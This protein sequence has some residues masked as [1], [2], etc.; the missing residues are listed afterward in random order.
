[1]D[2]RKEVEN[3]GHQK[4]KEGETIE[5]E[6]KDIAAEEDQTNSANNENK[7]TTDPASN[8]TTP[9]LESQVRQQY[10]GMAI[11]LGLFPL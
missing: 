11:T 10:F 8:G 9:S 3:V 6:D 7:L 1:M 5:K 4:M 2:S